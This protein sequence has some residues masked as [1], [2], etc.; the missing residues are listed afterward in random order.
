MGRGRAV[1]VIPTHPRASRSGTSRRSLRSTL[2]RRAAQCSRRPVAAVLPHA[3]STS[4]TR[5]RFRGLAWLSFPTRSAATGTGCWTRA[6]RAVPSQR[7]RDG[8]LAVQL[9]LRPMMATRVMAAPGPPSHR[10]SRRVRP[11]IRSSTVAS[12]CTSIPPPA[13][14][15]ACAGRDANWWTR[16]GAD[17]TA[18]ATSAAATR[19]GR[20]MP[21]TLGIEVLDDGPLVATLRITSDA[22]GAA[23]A[24]A[25]C[26]AARR[27]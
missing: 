19:A 17:G 16:D 15:R 22:P 14:W 6:V 7:L 3:A 21:R 25:R 26:H 4:G 27:Q 13:R 20:R 5:T 12:S 10:S 8:S 18:I 24:R 11:G 23:G 1:S 9:A 2:T